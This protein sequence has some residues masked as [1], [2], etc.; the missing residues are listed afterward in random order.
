LV[1]DV[2]D[3]LVDC[4]NA[5]LHGERTDIFVYCKINVTKR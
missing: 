3:G 2:R 5:A 4:S 1:I